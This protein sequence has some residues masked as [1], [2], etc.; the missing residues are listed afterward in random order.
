MTASSVTR[1][2]AALGAPPTPSECS[3]ELAE[4]HPSKVGVAW[5]A[6]KILQR[7]VEAVPARSPLT[8]RHEPAA[9]ALFLATFDLA[10]KLKRPKL[11]PDPLREV[12]NRHCPL[13]E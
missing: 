9:D 13:A 1:A 12:P 7:Q 8:R 5:G 10:L 4:H 11:G 6:L 3:S 2:R